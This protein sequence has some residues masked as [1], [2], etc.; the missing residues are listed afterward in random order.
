MVANLPENLI[1][2]AGFESNDPKTNFIGHPP[3][4]SQV[5]GNQYNCLNDF[6]NIKA[7]VTG[8]THRPLL[9]FEVAKEACGYEIFFLVSYSSISGDE[10]RADRFFLDS[11]H[12]LMDMFFRSSKIVIQKIEISYVC[13]RTSDILLK[14][15][16]LSSSSRIL[17]FISMA[18]KVD[19]YQDTLQETLD[20]ADRFAAMLSDFGFELRRCELEWDRKRNATG[21]LSKP[22]HGHSVVIRRR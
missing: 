20:H 7:E 15:D 21:P 6:V 19:I 11:Q 9:D 22:R 16:N 8:Q 13:E 4:H 12:D 18:H 17:G 2:F 3:N 1:L 14:L 10:Y 5:S